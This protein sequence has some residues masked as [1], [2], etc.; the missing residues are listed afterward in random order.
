[1]HQTIRHPGSQTVRPRIQLATIIVAVALGVSDPASGVA[2]ANLAAH[3]A[4]TTARQPA[5]QVVR[6]STTG[7]DWGDAAIGAAAGFGLSML[8]LGGGLVIAGA[9]RPGQPSGVGEREDTQQAIPGTP[10][11]EPH[12][13][14][15][16]PEQTGRTR[17]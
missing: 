12:S 11:P 8:A 1:M 2:R 9:R 5:A 7:F 15:L 17:S 13:K 10:T 3:S 6:V 16:T 14:Q 4:M